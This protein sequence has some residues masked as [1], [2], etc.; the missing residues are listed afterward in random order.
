M[1][2]PMLHAVQGDV[3]IVI[4]D[5]PCQLTTTVSNLPYRATWNEKGKVYEGCVGSSPEVGVA[6]FYFLE[7][8]TIAAVPLQMFVKVTTI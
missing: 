6:M 2:D 4:Y 8:K 5:E 3:R 1:A 7:D